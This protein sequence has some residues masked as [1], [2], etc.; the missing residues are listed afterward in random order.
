MLLDP[1]SKNIK[2]FSPISSQK[3]GRDKVH[4]HAG[5]AKTLVVRNDPNDRNEIKTARV[6][7]YDQI[8]GA[9]FFDLSMLYVMMGT[10]NQPP[11]SSSN[12]KIIT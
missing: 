5:L 2:C 11:Y 8:E 7:N 1:Q 10:Q 4:G 12:N 6:Y 9:I 3:P